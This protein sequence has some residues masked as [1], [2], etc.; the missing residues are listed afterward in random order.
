[1]SL[2]GH[3][4]L[5]DHEGDV[6]IDA[7]QATLAFVRDRRVRER[8]SEAS[9]LPLMTVA[10]LTGHLIH[11]GI[12][13][14]GEA[15]DIAHVTGSKPV[16]AARMLSWVPFDPDDPVHAGVRGV[17]GA[18]AA[19]GLDDLVERAT[20][21][22]DAITPVVSAVDPDRE[23]AF[24]W[25]PTLSMTAR[26]LFRSRIVELVVHLDDL[27]HSVGEEDIPLDAEAISI[28]CHVATDIVVLRHGPT[29][30]VRALCRPDRN[31][32]DALRTF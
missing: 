8:W 9:S 13:M 25:T 11:S 14:V 12:L 2:S 21:S 23:L 29:A 19:E 10:E 4:A 27:A 6:W 16:T 7:S 20:R 18:H 3:Y 31:S 5:V 17:A 32:I 1:M 26:E 24:P 30:V 22:L 15:F 28:A